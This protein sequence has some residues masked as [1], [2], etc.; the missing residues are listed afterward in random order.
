MI[1]QLFDKEEPRVLIVRT[2]AF[3]DIVQGLPVLE[4]LKE[5]RPRSRVGWVVEDRFAE[6]LE[7]HPAIDA[8]IPIRSRK[9]RKTP[10]DS[11]TQNEIRTTRNALQSFDAE[12]ALDL[13]SNFKA[14][15]LTRLSGAKCRG[16]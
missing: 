5:L 14:A 16:G 9:W 7:G 2:S 10:F 11:E 1:G 3:G 6:L 8:L 13:M 12:I 4:A 15:S